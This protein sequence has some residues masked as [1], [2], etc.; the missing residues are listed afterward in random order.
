MSLETV[1][2]FAINA[3]FTKGNEL[4]RGFLNR[5]TIFLYGDY[6]RN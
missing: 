1:A 6:L 5:L 2:K 4:I 3:M